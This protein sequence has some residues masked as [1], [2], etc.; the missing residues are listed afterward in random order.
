MA[1]LDVLI[2][3]LRFAPRLQNLSQEEIADLFQTTVK[4]SRAVETEHGTNSSTI[5]VQDGRFAGQT[6]P[7]SIVS[8]V[9]IVR[10][11]RGWGKIGEHFYC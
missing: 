11:F 2:S 10:G 6:V 1:L 3:T 5:C 4:V 9:C 8:N 7:V